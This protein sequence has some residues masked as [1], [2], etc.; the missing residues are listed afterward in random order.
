MNLVI[1][2]RDGVVNFD[3]DDYIKSPEEW[4]AI[5]GSLE[6]VKRLNDA[7]YLV[8]LATNQ[9]GPARGKFPREQL[10]LIFEK[11][12]HELAAIGGHFDYVA[13]CLHHP[14]DDCECRKPKP[15]LLLEIAEK[16][17]ADLTQSV[18]VGDSFKDIEAARAV[19]ARPIL[20]R[21]GKGERTEQENPEAG[22]TI[23]DNL[24]GFVKDFMS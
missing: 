4:H 22:V 11:M 1:L 13:M 17:N 14:N 19:G 5:P 6:A 20:V 15:G 8:A 21:T 10:G 7:G 16:L 9:A 18:F 23:Y 24:S 3:S 12:H 2:D